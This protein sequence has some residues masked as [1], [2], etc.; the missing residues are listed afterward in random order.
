VNGGTYNH[1]ERAIRQVGSLTGAFT[2]LGAFTMHER[3]RMQTTS[4]S[5]AVSPFLN[6]IYFEIIHA[7]VQCLTLNDHITTALLH[8]SAWD[9]F[10][11]MQAHD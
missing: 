11:T 9:C 1:C 3:E 10:R 6:Q 2:A 5:A 4:R 7:C 8:S